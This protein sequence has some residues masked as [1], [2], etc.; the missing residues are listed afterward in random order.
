MTLPRP[1]VDALAA[2]LAAT[3][4]GHRR[5]TGRMPSL[6]EVA[7]ALG[8]SV[9]D[10]RRAVAEVQSAARRGHPEA[11][12]KGPI[13]RP[14]PPA[15]RAAWYALREA[16]QV[17]TAPAVAGRLRDWEGRDARRHRLRQLASRD[18]QPAARWV[19]AYR[20]EHG[21]GPTWGELGKAM[22]WPYALR[23]DLVRIIAAGGGGWLQFEERQ[24]RSLAV[25]PLA[26]RDTA[27]GWDQ[28]PT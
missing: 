1:A 24:E 16:G 25:G 8:W 14:G 26:G 21:R 28:G 9:A 5:R 7:T 18:G 6:V 27:P 2:Q 12:Q 20:A 3:V 22:G 15:E 17:P 19:A 11:G 23:G 13:R 4:T 10:T